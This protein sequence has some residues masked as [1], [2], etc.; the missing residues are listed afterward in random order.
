MSTGVFG[1]LDIYLDTS[2][3]ERHIASLLQCEL[4]VQT[5]MKPALHPDEYAWDYFIAG[6]QS[7]RGSASVMQVIDSRGH[8]ETYLQQIEALSLS[9]TKRHISTDSAWGMPGRRDSVVH[10]RCR[11]SRRSRP[12]SRHHPRR[13][14]RPSGIFSISPILPAPM[15]SSVN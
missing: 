6:T 10:S 13:L 5:E 1:T 8:R 14:R 7:W 2:G 3:T 15:Q 11:A 9:K 4:N 12:Q